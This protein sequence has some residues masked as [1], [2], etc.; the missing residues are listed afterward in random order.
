M[1]RF[2]IGAYGA[3]GLLLAGSVYLA[4]TSYEGLVEDN[5]SRKAERYLM[6]K[7]AER[8]AGVT[9]DVTG[10]VRDGESRVTVE[11]ATARG[12]LRGAEVT[13]TAR[14][15]RGAA[16]DRIFR[17]AEQEPGTYAGRIDLPA[18]GSWL[19]DLSVRG[20][21]IRAQRRWTAD[22]GS[23]SRPAADSAR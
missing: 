19:M 20:A 5:Y 14:R 9:V 16:L 8:T 10:P 12:R 17:L 6:E 21:G 23:R 4:Q 22:V 18:A 13:L 11:V 1:K 15:I 3:F 7:E 2:L